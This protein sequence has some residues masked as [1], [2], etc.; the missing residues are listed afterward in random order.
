MKL[1]RTATR[2][3]ARRETEGA[4]I[5]CTGAHES[6]AARALVAAGLAV[7]YD[8]QSRTIAGRTYWNHFTR[9]YCT[10]RPHTD[11]GGILYFA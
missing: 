3:L 4:R 1:P 8:N 6:G 5:V 10:A 2:L 11:I 7:R 9:R